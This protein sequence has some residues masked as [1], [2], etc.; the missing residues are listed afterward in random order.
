MHFIF[1]KRGNSP[2]TLKLW[3][4]R[5]R[6]LKPEKKTRIV[7]KGTDNERLQEYRPSQQVRKRIAELNVQIC[8]R[9][10]SFCETLGTT[11]LK[12]FQLNKLKLESWITQS[13]DTESQ[14]SNIR[15]AKCPTNAIKKFRKHETV[16]LIR[17]KQT[18]ETNTLDDEHNE[19]NEETIK[20]AEK[21]FA[22]DL[23]MQVEKTARD[24]KIL[25]AIT[26]IERQNIEEIFYP[27]RPHRYHL[28]TKFDLLFYNDKIVIPEAMRTTIFAMLHQGHTSTDKMDQ[29][30]TAF[31]WPGL[32]RETGEKAENFPS[33][34]ASGKNLTTQLPST[35]KNNLE[36][37][38][39]TNQEIQLD[40][41]GP[42]KS[43]TRG[44]VYILVA[45]DRF[46]KWPTAQI[47]KK[48]DSRTVLKFLTKYCSNNGT[49][50][51]IRTD[52]G[53]CFKSSEFKEFCNQENIKRIRCT[54][55]LHTGTG[56]VERTIRTIKSLTRANM[57]DGLTFEEKVNLAIKTIRQTP[58]SKLNMTPFQIHFGRK[59]R[60][61][62]TN[63]IGRPECLLSN[64]KKTFPNYV[65]AQPTELQ[66]FTIN[67]SEGEM[68]DYMI[69][70]DSKKRARSVSRE[71]K[72]YQFFEKENKSN[73]MKCRFKTNKIL[74]AVSETKHTITEGKVIHKKLASKPIKLQ[75]S[76]KP[77][78][79]ENKPTA[80]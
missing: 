45:V 15:Q 65:L 9:F 38:S 53:R 47:C 70:N 74:T 80:A 4:E 32:H 69:L 67:D 56:Q 33:C 11:P 23:P 39:E 72:Q 78:E 7:G 64:W 51:S 50:R 29:S 40:F 68:A 16:K 35:E 79:K 18:V 77:E 44:D 20:K 3:T 17:L 2:D 43:K 26:A 12:E 76:K 42:I 36:I 6:L 37:L 28:T 8:N 75:S 21:D 59:P 54:P 5:K 1:K 13:S 30:S 73:A 34:R 48:T 22:L 27:Y 58:H 10:F 19:R 52:N 41:V 24:E 14:T 66:M 57:A 71:F 31:W 61:A 63:L 46:S 60:T 55:N 49:P 62:I 25:N